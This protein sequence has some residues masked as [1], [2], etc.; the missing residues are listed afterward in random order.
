MWSIRLVIEL[1]DLAETW[2]GQ[3]EQYHNNVI[4]RL[5]IS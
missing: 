1:I 2:I 3:R 5:S 4:T